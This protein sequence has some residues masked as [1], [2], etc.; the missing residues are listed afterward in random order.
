M[1]ADF[2]TQDPDAQKYEEVQDQKALLSIIEEYLVDY[3]S[4][5]KNRMD[6]VLFLY[7]AEHICRISRVIK[8]P[9]G[10]CL[11]VGV[12]GSGRQSLTRIATFMA[13]FQ[14]FS[15]EITKNYTADQWRDDLKSVL[16]KAGADG[17]SVSFIFSDTQV[18]EESFLEDIN[19]IL[20]T[21]EVPNLFPKDELFSIM[22]QVRMLLPICITSVLHKLPR[23]V[24][25][26]DDPVPD[27]R[28]LQTAGDAQG[29]EI[30]AR[31]DPKRALCLLCG[32]VPE[33][34]SHGDL[35]EPGWGRVP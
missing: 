7:A 29:E 15:I 12:G 23:S 33:Q 25:V 2:K 4:Q 28:W 32:A 1:F 19:N 16:K 18:K 35:H 21:G 31:A 9:Y 20:N 26:P 30:G 17:V 27:D 5:S 10:N 14:P 24:S 6:L 3:N 22:E 34:S 13:D 11:L 8:Q